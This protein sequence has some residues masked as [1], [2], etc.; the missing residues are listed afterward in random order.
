MSIYKE[1]SDLIFRENKLKKGEDFINY[2]VNI[3][4]I[5]NDFILEPDN[6]KVENKYKNLVKLMLDYITFDDWI[7][8]LISFCEKFQSYQV[9]KKSIND[10]LPD[11]IHA[12]ERKT[13]VEWVAGF[14][15]TERIVSLNKIIE[16]IEKSN[17]PKEVITKLNEL[18]DKNLNERFKENIDGRD[19]YDEDF[20]KY[21]LLR[22]DLERWDQ[23]SFSGYKPPITIEHI[24]PQNP[25][26]NSEWVRLFT[27]KI[28][29]EMTN[30]IGN[31]V[32]L[33]RKKNSGARNYDFK[34]KKEVYFFKGGSTPFKITSEIE[35][36]DNWN[37][38][39]LKR[40]QEEMVQKL[41]EIYFGV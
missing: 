27:E 16:L 26:E 8:P 20:A 37:E 5:Y 11:F 25:S 12:L 30:K 22:M 31:L 15:P 3:S 19:F 38:E 10:F 18:T 33:G 36:I 1:Y 29:E 17:S 23:E 34:K 40:R 6:L 14:T 35:K 41:L 32:L 4:K 9:D 7:P 21:L 13:V 28:R 2:F 24:L 39:S